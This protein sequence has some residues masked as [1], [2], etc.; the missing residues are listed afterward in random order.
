MEYELPVEGDWIIIGVLAEKSDI[1]FIGS[2]GQNPSMLEKQ[3]KALEAEVKRRKAQEKAKLAK[4]KKELAS[5][6]GGNGDVDMELPGDIE[7]DNELKA[8]DSGDED[9]PAARLAAL[10]RKPRRYISFKLIDLRHRNAGGGSGIVN[11]KLFEADPQ[12]EAVKQVCSSDDEYTTSKGI[13]MKK[14]HR[15][16]RDVDVETTTRVYKGGSGGAY[17][18]FWKEREGTVVAILNP[19]IMKPWQVSCATNTVWPIST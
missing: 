11:L 5:S 2:G 1:R 15:R 7:S 3:K 12:K 17:E 14:E 6:A 18:K 10:N 19:R 4:L 9:D 16:D 13:R 8:A